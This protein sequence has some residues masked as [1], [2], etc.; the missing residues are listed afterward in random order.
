MMHTHCYDIPALC[1]FIVGILAVAAYG[2]FA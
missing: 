2:V 1:V